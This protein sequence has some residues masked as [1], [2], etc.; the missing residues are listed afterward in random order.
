M[1]HSFCPN[2]SLHVP[3]PGAE[4]VLAA[5]QAHIQ[6]S[7]IRQQSAI[8]RTGWN[9]YVF[10]LSYRTGLRQSTLPGERN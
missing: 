5:V 10:N 2:L 8:G 6:G 4:A 7:K 1:S 3:E 9:G